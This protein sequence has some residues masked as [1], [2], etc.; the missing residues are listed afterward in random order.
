MMLIDAEEL[1][2]KEL[3]EIIRNSEGPCQIKA[4]LGQ[5][6]IAAGMSNQDIKIKGIPGNASV[7][8]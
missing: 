6:F 7:P 2:H 5:R 4:C 8:I 1:D 3:N